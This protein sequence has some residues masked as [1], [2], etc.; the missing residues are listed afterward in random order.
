[1]ER[2]GVERP[3]GI[4]GMTKTHG[5]THWEPDTCFGCKVSTIDF[6]YPWGRSFFHDS[7][8]PERLREVKAECAQAA[9]EGNHFEP[10]PVRAQYW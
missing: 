9:L 6:G 1:V 8:I 4:D 7:C 2:A 10:K 5:V 3:L